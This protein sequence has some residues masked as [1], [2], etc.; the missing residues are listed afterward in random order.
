M[1]PS[2]TIVIP[3][4][5]RADIVGRTLQSVAA[6]TLR[7]LSVVLV[8]NGSTD[9]T[10]EVLRQWKAAVES[11]DFTVEVIEE[12]R[13]G[14]SA[15]RNAGLAAVKTEWTMFFDSDDIMLPDHARRA[16]EAAVAR[17]DADMVGWP[18]RICDGEGRP[19]AL[20]KFWAEDMTYFN[21]FRSIT[22]SQQYMARTELFRRAGGWDE[23]L[24]IAE[25]IE[26]GQRI[27]SL[28]PVCVKAGG[29]PTVLVIE[30]GVSLMRHG[31]GRYAKLKA[32]HDKIRK[33]LPADKRHWVDLQAILMGRG[34]GRGDAC[35][36]TAI[37]EILA[38]T[39]RRRRWLWRLFDMY[40]SHGGRG[41]WMLYYPLRDLF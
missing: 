15:A 23:S 27:L 32:A 35:A 38:T 4:Y 17:P 3:V 14:P 9:A 34:W 25:D 20:R 33:I 31:D 18:M 1:K 11:P 26:L 21:I 30:T 2:V 13:R 37:D 10:P 5:N 36:A 22:S 39:P 28:S 19:R 7:P 24:S 41:T 29:A 12:T 16:C 8:D 6:Q 40:A